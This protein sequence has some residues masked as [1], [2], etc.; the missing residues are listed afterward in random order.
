MLGRFLAIF[1]RGERWRLAGLLGLT[2]AGGVL[3]TVGVGVV[4]PYLALVSDS[5]LTERYTWLANLHSQLGSPSHGALLVIVSLA[6]IVFFL[7]K[8]GYM[9]WLQDRQV[10]FANTK[11]VDLSRRLL[12]SYFLRPY[13]QQLAGSSSVMARDLTYSVT[14][15]CNGLI[16]ASL[17]LATD[18]FAAAGILA[19]LL[20]VEPTATLVGG[21]TLITFGW[22]LYRFLRGRIALYSRRQHRELGDMLRQAGEAAGALKEVRILGVEGF[23]LDRFRDSALRNTRDLRLFQFV[24]SLPKAS[25]EMLLTFLLAGAVVLLVIGRQDIAAALPLLGVFAAAAVRLMPMVSRVST[26]LNTARKAMPSLEVVIDA[27]ETLKSAATAGIVLPARAEISFE[28]QIRMDRVAFRYRSQN[29]SLFDGFS[30]D[31]RCGER[32]ALIGRT[33][34]GKSTLLDLLLGLLEPEA[35]SV[36]VDGVNIRDNLRSWRNLIGY[37]PQHIYL[38]DDSVR[39]NVAL[40]IPDEQIDEQ[41]VWQVLEMAEMAAVVRALPDGLQ[42]RVGERGGLL[43]GG[44]RQRI[45]IA[46]ALYHEPRILL[47]DE[48]TS[49]LDNETESRVLRT[50][51][52][53]THERT[54]IMIAHRLSSVQQ[55]ER[56]ILMDTGRIVDEGTFAEI[57][58]RHPDFV[59]PDRS[60][61]D[62]SRV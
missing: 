14:E 55:C 3:E 45:G 26:R 21:V 60:R 50:I 5:S 24:N 42:A 34:S 17:G 29:R 9:V 16:F 8:N 35:G 49:A 56:V 19:T 23:F 41:R 13:Q 47:M 39:R 27:L 57:A 31:I 38:L 43:S 32:V 18:V 59:N 51:D 36:L 44:Q 1:E 37:I 58:Q 46:R 28:K 20:F 11:Q 25:A 62:P 15:V 7:F 2:L 10:R 52:R 53:L 4:L 33:G 40:G 6:L 54:L 30:L 61:A 12:A 48:A 22:L